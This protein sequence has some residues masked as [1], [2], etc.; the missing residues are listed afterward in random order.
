M[1]P[2]K[3]NSLK[4]DIAKE[5]GVHEDVVDA[6]IEFY[7]EKLRYS[8]SNLVY[9]KVYVN[10]LGTFTIRKSVLEKNIKKQKDILG[11]LKK[12]T[13]NGYEKSVSVQDKIKL[14]EK[15]LADVNTLQQNKLD[16]KKNKNGS[17]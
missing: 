15:A 1:N 4:V 10:N 3:A 2:K 7:Y 12:L 11:N 5:V 8:L 16:F 17:K 14:Y 6:F 9:P 13:Y